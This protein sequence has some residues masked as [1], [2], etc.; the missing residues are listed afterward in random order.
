MSVNQVAWHE[1]GNLISYDNLQA[2][3]T[4]LLLRISLIKRVI[5]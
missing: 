2:Y 5:N 1:L 4:N 3:I